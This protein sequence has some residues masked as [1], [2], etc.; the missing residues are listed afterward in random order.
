MSLVFAVLKIS[1]EIPV[2]LFSDIVVSI[3]SDDI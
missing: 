1:L 2:V 3:S